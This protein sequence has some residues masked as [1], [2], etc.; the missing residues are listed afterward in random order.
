MGKCQSD[1]ESDE[2]DWRY[3][4]EWGYKHRLTVR[5][6]H[7]FHVPFKLSRRLTKFNFR[8]RPPPPPCW[9]PSIFVSMTQSHLSAL[10][11]LR[12]CE[13]VFFLI[14]ISDALDEKRNYSMRFQFVSQP[15]I[16]DASVRWVVTSTVLGDRSTHPR[17]TYAK[18]LIWPKYDDSFFP[19]VCPTGPHASI[20]DLSCHTINSTSGC[21]CPMNMVSCMQ[22]DSADCSVKGLKG[23]LHV[24]LSLTW[25]CD[26][27]TV[28]AVIWR[29]LL[30]ADTL[31]VLETNLEKKIDWSRQELFFQNKPKNKPLPKSISV[32]L[33]EHCLGD[34]LVVCCIS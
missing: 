29:R 11:N 7:V 34:T 31:N 15:D 1:V 27:I 14:I 9:P 23:F 8:K 33:Q 3:I 2:V 10:Q 4:A 22:N 28:P 5:F 13:F 19:T 32:N 24:A 18:V 21:M 25:W 17:I 26:D 20:Q 6:H 30:V 16:Y 12:N